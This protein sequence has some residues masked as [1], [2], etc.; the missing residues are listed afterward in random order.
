MK[1]IFTFASAMMAALSAIVYDTVTEGE[2][3]YG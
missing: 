2:A 3:Y 1:K